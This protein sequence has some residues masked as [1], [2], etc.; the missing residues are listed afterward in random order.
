M[1]SP[2]SLD[3][4]HH[5]TLKLKNE[6]PQTVLT[7]NA[8]FYHLVVFGNSFTKNAS[9]TKTLHKKYLCAR[10][11]FFNTNKSSYASKFCLDD[12]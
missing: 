3:Q 6:V 2:Q 12:Y 5:K 10:R 1:S 9:P 11:E 4:L 7:V 8:V